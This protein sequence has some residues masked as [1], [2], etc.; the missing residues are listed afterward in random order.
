MII[1][2]Y[3]TT[4]IKI[5][6][7]SSQA[8]QSIAAMGSESSMKIR[9]NE[10][11]EWK[12]DNENNEI[13]NNTSPTESKELEAEITITFHKPKPINLRKILKLKHQTRSK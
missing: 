9:N 10:D 8:V 13:G 7:T 6:T 2:A 3:Y 11:Q 1:S 12:S 4:L 5:R